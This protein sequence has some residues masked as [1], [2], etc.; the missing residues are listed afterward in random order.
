MSVYE[1]FGMCHVGVVK[2]C[3][4]VEEVKRQTKWFGHMERM[5]EGKMTRRVYMSETEGV[6]VRGRPAV[7]WRDRVQEA[8]RECPDR[9]RWKLFCCGHPLVQWFPTFLAAYSE[10]FLSEAATTT[11]FIIP[12]TH[13][14]P[15]RTWLKAVH[16]KTLECQTLLLFNGLRQPKFKVGNH[17]SRG[18]TLKNW[19]VGR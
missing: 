10:Y 5:Q 13:Y 15:L 17:R 4:V 18:F 2:K 14:L 1:R 16:F 9:E 3:G 11:P 6:N 19:N 8:K 7:K 12:A